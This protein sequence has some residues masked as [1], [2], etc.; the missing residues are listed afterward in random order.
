MTNRQLTADLAVVGTGVAGLSAAL[1]A[2]ELG[3]RVVAL[4]KNTIEDGNT[5]W[6][7]G[8]VAVVLPGSGDSVDAHVADTLAA[9]A[10]LGDEAAARSILAAGP[11][12]V[13]ALRARGA[14][15]DGSAGELEHT[16]E[17]G[18]RAF[19]VIHAGGD[20]TGAEIE[21]ALAGA[22]Q[23]GQLP[24][25]EGQSVTDVL[26]D[27]TGR[28]A[29]L[30][31]L[32]EALGTG[33]LRS[34]AVLLA[35]G[36]LGQLYTVSTNA[37]AATGDG[38]ALALRAGA[39]TADL[40]FVQFHPTVLHLGAGSRGRQPL[41]T[42]AIRGEGAVL[43]DITG[44]PVMT[45][46]HPLGALAPRDVVAAA[47]TRRMAQTGS[48][49][50][51]LDT[52]HLGSAELRRRF[53]TVHAVCV[54]L[55]LDPAREPIPVAPAAHYQCGGVVTDTSGRST[56]PGLYAAGEVARTGLHGANRLASNSLL[57]GLVV[58][59]R[60]AE[61]VAADLAVSPRPGPPLPPCPLRLVGDRD[62][63]QRSMSAH[64]G[65][66]RDATG[67]AAAATVVR[68]AP[69]RR[70]RTPR[71][72]EDAG[73]TL[74]AAAVLAAASARTET[75]GCHLRTD[76]P[77]TAARWQRSITVVLDDVGTPVVAQPMLVG[78]VA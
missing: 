54:A 36:G 61:A 64:A 74:A 4:T 5:R 71:D 57:E 19:R 67:L 12:A 39:M 72:A 8:G 38:L 77:R 51:L 21:R 41:V 10:G 6:A 52:T 73:L 1:R 31:L 42:E 50:V 35:T 48:D 20:A 25:L 11:A 24:V 37:D 46:V 28:V 33:V 55:G 14:V 27:D 43:L 53:P 32:G 40:E 7:Q 47:I 9:S 49:H 68:A 78:G 60:A 62:A 13:S 2:A 56:V 65:I 17:G 63:I 59:T 34:R 30:A 58:G 22:A 66:G 3:L 44:A 16:R 29:G 75:R 26:R 23:S 45:G 18:H 69:W 76:H 15:F 70:L